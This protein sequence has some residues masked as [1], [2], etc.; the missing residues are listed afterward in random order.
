[1]PRCMN[2]SSISR[3]RP[4]YPPNTLVPRTLSLAPVLLHH[5]LD[6]GGAVE[7]QDVFHL[8]A[9]ADELD[10]QAKLGWDGQHDPPWRFRRA[11]VSTIP[12]TARGWVRAAPAAGRS[13]RWWRPSPAVSG[14]ARGTSAVSVRGASCPAPCHQVGL[15]CRR[16][17]V[18]TMSTSVA[19]ALAAVHRI[20]EPQP[21]G[22]PP[23]LVLI[24]GNFASARPRPQAARWPPREM[25]LPRRAEPSGPARSSTP[26]ACRRRCLAGAVDA[27]HHHHLGRRRGVA[28][29]WPLRR[30]RT[31]VR[32]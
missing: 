16:P 18:S 23:V 27:D 7:G 2:F 8:L 5:R 1:M 24:N 3:D 20:E 11:L 4:S 30:A 25:C 12:V 31:S 10:G 29:S 15:V 22:S 6:E 21:K 19:R 28:S 26:R 14:G 9:H 17:A 32:A 13:G